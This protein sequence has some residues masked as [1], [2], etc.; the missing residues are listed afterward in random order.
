MV[1]TQQRAAAN[2]RGPTRVVG[3][4]NARGRRV[5]TV[6]E[7][8]TL[9]DLRDADRVA[10]RASKQRRLVATWRREDVRSH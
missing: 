6:S 3:A 2:A 10:L 4:S 8:P 7:E 5:A 9:R 1:I